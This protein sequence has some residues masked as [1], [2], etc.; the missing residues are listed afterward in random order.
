MQKFPPQQLASVA[1]AFDEVPGLSP[2]H[3][4]A[5]RAA[6]SKLDEARDEEFGDKYMNAVKRLA[7]D[8]AT[9]ACLE[10]KSCEVAAC[11]ILRCC[12]AARVEVGCEA[13][14]CNL[15]CNLGQ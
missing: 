2:E 5:L 12:D 11:L 10:L 4:R 13:A 9:R 7:D 15:G 1:G 6:R 8:A 3:A 14:L